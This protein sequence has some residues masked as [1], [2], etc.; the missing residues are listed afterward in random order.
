MFTDKKDLSH[1]V[2]HDLIAEKS[3]RS[4]AALKHCRI[5]CIL[6]AIVNK[7]TPMECTHLFHSN[8][9]SLNAEQTNKLMKYCIIIDKVINNLILITLQKKHTLNR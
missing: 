9:K 3:V 2:V 5:N 8:H 4:Q 6:L 7:L 1:Q